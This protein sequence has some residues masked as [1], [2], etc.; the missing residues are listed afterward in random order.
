M[1]IN[2]SG[3]IVG[4]FE[5]QNGTHGSVARA[6]ITSDPTC[7]VSSPDSGRYQSPKRFRRFLVRLAPPSVGETA[8]TMLRERK[9]G[10]VQRFFRG[11]GA[12]QL[13]PTEL[14]NTGQ[15]P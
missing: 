13:P 2:D 3:Q 15:H 12:M 10:R 14:T 1:S 7:V 4:Y 6:C 8:P 9:I 5:D 11:P